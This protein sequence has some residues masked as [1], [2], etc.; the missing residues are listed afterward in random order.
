MKHP[1][2]LPVTFAL[3][4]TAAAPSASTW[5]AKPPATAA[6]S[7]QAATVT[8]T[9]KETMNAGGYT[10][11]RLE[12]NGKDVWIAASE[13][14]VKV[15]ER[16]TTALDVPMQNFHSKTLNRDFPVIYFVGRVSRDGAATPAPAAPAMASSHAPAQGAAAAPTVEKIA[17]PPGGLSIAD[18]WAKRTTLAGK[19]ILVRGKVVKV[20]NAIMVR[21]WVHLQDGSGA[22]KDGTHDLTVTTTE[23]VTVGDIVTLSGTLAVDKDFTEGYT[24]AAI[25][26]NAT[27]KK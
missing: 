11:V 15:G 5:Q 4:Y 14:A 9:V 7:S 13:F 23:T 6:Q 8:G 12:A 24:Y 22:A 3:L 1:A 21:N 26:E 19:A 17:P 20:N 16:V 2:I 10:Y 18:V 25:L 27:I